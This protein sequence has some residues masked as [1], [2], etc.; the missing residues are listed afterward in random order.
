MNDISTMQPSPGAFMTVGLP[1]K[2]SLVLGE[3][4]GIFGSALLGWKEHAW[5]ICEWPSQIAHGTEIPRGTACSVSYEHAGQLVGYRSEIRDL[6]SA[7][8]PLLFLAYPQIVESMHLR[9]YV[10]VS[11]R[12]PVLLERAE[13]GMGHGGHRPSADMLGG[14][15]RDLSLGGCSVVLSQSHH[16]IKPG[17]KV[18]MAFELAGLGHV[19]NL[20]GIVKSADFHD[21]TCLVGIEFRF[22]E[23]EYIEYRGWGGSVQQ[24]IQK[25]TSQKGAEH[26]SAW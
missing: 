19:T 22:Q 20:T 18:R 7:P 25:W 10:R 12:E 4:Q 16:W 24:A 3:Q 17:Q 26:F 6:V 21:S 13:G 14:I 5:L 23:M 2:L 9:K 1:L 15:L 8:V 11:S